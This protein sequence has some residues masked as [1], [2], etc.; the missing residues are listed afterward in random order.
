M[1]NSIQSL[2]W[3]LAVLPFLTNASTFPQDSFNLIKRVIEPVPEQKNKNKTDN[4]KSTNDQPENEKSQFPIL[5]SERL[6]PHDG[7]F[8]GVDYLNNNELKNALDVQ[9]SFKYLFTRSKL[10]EYKID[11]TLQ[12]SDWDW[13]VAFSFT[14]EFDFYMGTRFSGPVVGRRYNPGLQVYWSKKVDV[15]SYGAWTTLGI[16]LEHESNGQTT[17]AAGDNG[18]TENL[19]PELAA[20]FKRI[21]A[22]HAHNTPEVYYQEM[23]TETI[24]RGYN[25]FAIYANHHL[26]ATNTWLYSFGWKLR[27]NVITDPDDFIF[28]DTKYADATFIKHK[29]TR[30]GLY[31]RTNVPANT[32]VFGCRIS[33]DKQG[34]AIEYRTGQIFNGNATSKNTVDITY[35]FDLGI[36]QNFRLPLFIKYH[37]GYLDEVFNYHV[38]QSK[39]L[40]GL[41]MNF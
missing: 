27:H 26:Y 16:A 29:G 40:V 22:D 5:S 41:H 3:L 36:G 15:K 7:N 11:P 30:L 32:A 20:N 19:L 6:K 9:F 18:V 10:D 17:H 34:F 39:W 28:W 14:G 4:Q 8:F 1:K 25:F 21:N 24:S 23:A 35:M 12:V 31:G 2:L 13:D 38:K 33:I 37:N